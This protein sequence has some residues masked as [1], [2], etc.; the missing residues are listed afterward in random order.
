MVQTF[1]KRWSSE[2]LNT[3]QIRNK[4]DKNTNPISLGTVILIKHDSFTPPL[5]WP[6]G[7]V[8]KLY[9][10]NDGI[11]RVVDVQTKSGLYKRPVAK[12]CPLPTQYFPLI[13]CQ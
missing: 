1:W 6:L 8:T 5:Q 3:L 12:L 2:Y 11:V 7:R 4:W 10:G 9:P 13:F